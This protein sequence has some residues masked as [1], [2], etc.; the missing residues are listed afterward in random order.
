MVIV[1]EFSKGFLVVFIL[2]HIGLILNF[3]L[4][5][6]EKLMVGSLIAL[7]MNTLYILYNNS[8]NTRTQQ[9]LIINIIQSNFNET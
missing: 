3:I 4:N 9:Q 1:T 7:P 5:F 2:L 6:I 8:A